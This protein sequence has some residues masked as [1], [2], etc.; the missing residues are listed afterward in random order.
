[1]DLS[2]EKADIV[3]RLGQIHDASLIT[4]IKSIL[5]FGIIKQE[6]SDATLEVSLRNG[7]VQSEQGETRSH[8]EVMA[9]L[10]KRFAL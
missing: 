8:E 7:L 9:D 1:M 5:D 4:A 3:R 6:E 10:R 2:S